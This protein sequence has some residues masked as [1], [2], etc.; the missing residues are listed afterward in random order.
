MPAPVKQYPPYCAPFHKSGIRR[1]SWGGVE[2]PIYG[3]CLYVV[4]FIFLCGVGFLKGLI[5]GIVAAFLCFKIGREM[6][7]KDP[8]M[9]E[10]YLC[11]WKYKAFHTA[12][13]RQARILRMQSNDHQTRRTSTTGRSLG[14]A[15]LSFG[16]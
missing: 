11:N 7:K 3:V 16:R 6:Y 14:P 10:I 5:L 12:L 8:Y 9:T 4:I 2:L 1:Y 13:P 15:P